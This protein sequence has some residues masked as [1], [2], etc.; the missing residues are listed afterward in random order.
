MMRSKKPVRAIV[1]AGRARGEGAGI[2]ATPS[3]QTHLALEC[4]GLAEA[5][6][7]MPLTITASPVAILALVCGLLLFGMSLRR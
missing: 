3:T 1:V 6:A 4:N 5:L 2:W 7:Q